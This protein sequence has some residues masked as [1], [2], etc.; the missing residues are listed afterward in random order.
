M[1]EGV[2]SDGQWCGRPPDGASCSRSAGL[3]QCQ[4][5]SPSM[6]YRTNYG[7]LLFGWL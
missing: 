4:S 5:D 7:W 6:L 3:Q 1:R 2:V